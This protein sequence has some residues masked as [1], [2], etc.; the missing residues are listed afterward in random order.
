MKFFLSY[1]LG[2]SIYALVWTVSALV[3]AGSVS[4]ILDHEWNGLAGFVALGAYALIILWPVNAVWVGWLAFFGTLQISGMRRWPNS[5]LMVSI[6][7][8]ILQAILAVPV[9]SALSLPPGGLD[10]QMSPSFFTYT[11]M[12]APAAFAAAMACAFVLGKAWRKIMR[13]KE[14]TTD[15]PVENEPIGHPWRY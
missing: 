8:G 1:L 12:Y 5:L 2:I 6:A 4:C 3:V 14:V 10:T 11:I 13:V 9:A 7:S 15:V